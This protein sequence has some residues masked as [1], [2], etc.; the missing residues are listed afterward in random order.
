MSEPRR[1]VLH[2]LHHLRGGS[3]F[4]R[5]HGRGRGMQVF[6]SSHQDVIYVLKFEYTE[7]CTRWYAFNFDELPSLFLTLHKK[8]FTHK[9]KS[10]RTNYFEEKLVLV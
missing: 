9:I 4:Q 7:G 6:F 2:H 5:W 3:G 8:I 10:L 1:L